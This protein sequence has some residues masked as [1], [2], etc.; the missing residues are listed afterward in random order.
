MLLILLLSGCLWSAL[1]NALQFR[2]NALLILLVIVKDDLRVLLVDSAKQGLLA[3]LKHI[4]LR[5]VLHSV[6][7]ENRCALFC[8]FN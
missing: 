1:G 5:Y 7:A 4:L 6:C 8:V 2:R 3:E